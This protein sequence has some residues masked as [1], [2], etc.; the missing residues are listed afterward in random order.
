MYKVFESRKLVFV[1]SSDKY[2]F[3][4]YTQSVILVTQ[5]I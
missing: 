5:A 3:L 1:W 4:V 2:A